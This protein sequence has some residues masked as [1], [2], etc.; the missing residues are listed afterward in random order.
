MV[1]GKGRVVGDGDEEVVM[2]MDEGP[3]AIDD[4]PHHLV[5]AQAQERGEPRRRGSAAPGRRRQAPARHPQAD[6]QRPEQVHAL[7]GEEVHDV[8]EPCVVERVVV[9][10]VVDREVHAS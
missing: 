3:R 2:V 5:D 7:V 1:G 4:P 8:L 9:Q 10:G 6:H